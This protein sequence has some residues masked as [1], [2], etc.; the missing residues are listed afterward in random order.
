MPMRIGYV[1][2]CLIVLLMQSSWIN[3]SSQVHM[4]VKLA[5]F[6]RF[7]LLHRFCTE[8]SFQGMPDFPSRVTLMS[9]ELFL[10]EQSHKWV[11][12]FELIIIIQAPRPI[13]VVEFLH[14][15]LNS[16]QLFCCVSSEQLEM[17][18]LFP[19]FLTGHQISHLR[20]VSF[21]ELLHF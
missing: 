21:L 15:T 6:P 19:L 18:I 16:P 10:K 7:L 2:S 20:D 1:G 13:E 17:F 4:S 5:R 12:I 3:C 8:H 9:Y 14:L 11:L